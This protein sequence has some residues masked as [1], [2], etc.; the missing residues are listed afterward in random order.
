MAVDIAPYAKAVVGGVVGG[1]TALAT[2]LVD[3]VIDP[4]EW[5]TI[6]LAVIAGSGFVYAVPN[7]PKKQE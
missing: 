5:T 3:G 2:A 4:V 1:L 6:A 7:A